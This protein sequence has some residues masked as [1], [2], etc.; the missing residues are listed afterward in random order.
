MQMKR[1][2][3]VVSYI[4]IIMALFV[5]LLPGVAEAGI[6]NADTDVTYK[7]YWAPHSQY[8]G[9]IED[10][11]T[12]SPS[13]PG[14]GSYYIEPWPRNCRKT[15][16]IN[17][18]DNFA[19]AL[20]IEVYIDLWR[21]QLTQS[22]KFKI[23]G[24]PTIYSPEVGFDWSR[25]P[26][27]AE[28]PKSEFV[29]G[30]N[31]F[32]FWQTGGGYHVHDLAIRVY[33]DDAHPLVAGPGSDVTPPN[34]QLVTVKGDD[35]PINAGDGGVLNLNN[36]QLVLTAN[37]SGTA[38]LVEFHGYYFGYDEDN[39]GKFTDWHNRGRVNWFPGGTEVQNPD[40]GGVIDH[41]GTQRTP[42]DGTY[43]VTYD[44][45]IIPDQNNVRFKI[46]IIDSAGNVREAAG[47]ASAPF[48]LRRT[49]PVV[50]F[51]NS[52]FQD[53]VLRLNGKPLE[54]DAYM[55]LPSAIT[56]F[57]AT[58]KQGKLV[59]S[60]WRAPKTQINGGS[61]ISPS[62]AKGDF[63]NLSSAPF[64]IN[65][66][67]AGNNNFHYLTGGGGAGE[68][69]EKPG[70]MV[71]VQRN[72]SA[73]SDT[74]PPQAY[75]FLPV[76]NTTVSSP[77]PLI[78]AHLFDLV[79]GVNR[80]SI[81][82]KVNGTPVN[83]LIEGTKYNYLVRYQ[84]TEAF[85]PGQTVP[86]TVDACD[87]DGRCMTT[88][89]WSFKI[90]QDPVLSTI[91]SD[92]FNRCSFGDVAAWS[93]VNPLNDATLNLVNG[94]QVAIAVPA[95][96][97]HDFTT[98]A[99]NAARI[100]QP[101][102][103]TDFEMDVK[104][105]SVFTA[106]QQLQGVM[107]EESA[108][109]YLQLRFQYRADGQVDFEAWD[110]NGGTVTKRRFT[111]LANASPLYMR[112]NRTGDTWR[113][114]YSLTGE[115][116]SWVRLQFDRIM[117][118]SKVGVFVGNT[119]AS[120]AF[121]GVID[122]VFNNAAP[123]SPEDA[124]A[125]I[126]PAIQVVGSGTVAKNPL[127]GKPVQLTATPETG[128]RFAGWSGSLTGT[129]NPATIA[130][131]TGSEAI[132]A[133]FKQIVT[134]A[135]NTVG[136]GT[137]TKNPD[138]ADYLAG[139][140]V[141]LTATPADGWVF[142]GWSGDATGTT[143]V[144]SVA[145]TGNKNITATFKQLFT[146]NVSAVGN[147][148]VTKGPDQAQYIDGDQVTLTA[149][150]ADGWAFAGWSG[151]FTGNT[152]PAVVTVNGNKTIVATFKQRRAL[153]IN[154]TGNGTVSKDPNKAEYADGDVVTLT[155]TPQTGWSFVGWSGAATGSASSTTITLDAD[156]TVTATF[157]QNF[158]LTVT[159]TGQG[160][161]ARTPDQVNYVDGTQVTL[162]ATAA[163]GWEFVGWGGDLTGAVN[164][165]TITMSG[166]KNVEAIFKQKFQLQVG[167]LGS[168]TVTVDPVKPYYLDGE[169]VQLTAAPAAGWAFTGWSGN[170]S[171][172]SNPINLQMDSNKI[173]TADFKPGLGLT[174]NMNGQ[175]S[176]Q[177]SPDKPIYNNGD[178]VT[179][180]AT[181][182]AG[183]TF[184]GWS[185]DATGTNP[186]VK[187]TMDESKTVTANFAELL[188]LNVTVVGEGTVTKNPD[189][190][191]YDAGDQIILT[192]TPATGWEFVGWSGDATGTVNP[193]TVTMTSSKAVTATFR[194]LEVEVNIAVGTGEEG[195][196]TVEPAAGPYYVGQVITL[197]ATANDGYI[198]NGWT[199]LVMTAD[200]TGG[201]LDKTNPLRI[202]LTGN[203]DIRANFAK[204]AGNVFLPL[205]T[206]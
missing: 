100:M 35:S 118:V 62:F 132:T 45:S 65:F 94:R 112:V 144:L 165:M 74:A 124:T 67:I 181:P 178:E 18:P 63:W 54:A 32:E 191:T 46:R 164:P 176:V 179:L 8:T 153:T 130:T 180:T 114:Y 29:Q 137:V 21:N 17:I 39:D 138:Q 48:E 204:V 149:T 79:A 157:K 44:A 156:K 158:A 123:I 49:N 110:H 172:R 95:G 57:Q 66:L 152:S 20:K 131:I 196:V 135:V 104:F 70:P 151:D 125:L 14:G 24:R 11:D 4:F 51:V 2:P 72:A 53:L 200:A 140:Q 201:Q 27:I 128:W 145:M 7:E 146:V 160:A 148:A 198:F 50:A 171:G 186:V 55:E 37:I 111:A 195:F 16:T 143:N 43:S 47:G 116:S 3:L 33:Y 206:R 134:L 36:N 192:A 78:T 167:I 41:L 92:D 121:T 184:T 170:L 40:L 113:V 38:K 205:V 154:V 93:F 194:R 199:D 120:P 31:S 117:V 22:A 99:A 19:N 87:L 60:F 141:T 52:V 127:C 90:Y 163:D 64:N 102:N 59:N 161:V 155:A 185:G 89:T 136:S 34:G 12:C 42:S 126:L 1:K 97:A 96:V 103:D 85:E 101:A 91:V 69:I 73:N 169:F 162:Q 71:V 23:N 122:Y 83:P 187:I 174:V 142:T 15:L 177:L 106:A 182:A 88:A 98:T 183:W 13:T 119:G 25:T 133:T 77:S 9:G 30:N 58:G 6:Y 75:S 188:T 203:L 68:F 108:T 109:S 197:T 159:T 107:I 5:A 28:I 193:L 80:N 202:T 105:E 61:S 139:D 10:I 86:V 168:G 82:L 115:A 190:A 76:N 175:G 129:Q 81:V 173:V 84:P 147:G 56:S 189:Q 26:W 150:P 166:A